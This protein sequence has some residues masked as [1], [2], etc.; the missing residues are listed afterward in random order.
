T[1]RRFLTC[2]FCFCALDTTTSRCSLPP[3]PSARASVNSTSKATIFG[4]F[5]PRPPRLDSTHVQFLSH[6]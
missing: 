3:S 6:D 1:S 4:S 5:P 2:F